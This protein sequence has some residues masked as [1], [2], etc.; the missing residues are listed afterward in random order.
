MREEKRV[1][2]R[3][4]AALAVTSML[5]VCPAVS[6]VIAS[7]EAP[8]SAASPGGG[9]DMRAVI[10]QFTADDSALESNLSRAR[11]RDSHDTPRQ[12]LRPRA[13]DVTEDGLRCA[14]R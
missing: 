10:E 1:W 3:K 13:G 4:A 7:S 14:F 2:S 11:L 9:G 8:A 5:F 6:P 12:V